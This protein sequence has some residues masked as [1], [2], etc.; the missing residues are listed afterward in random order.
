MSF[1]DIRYD[2]IRLL[3]N[4]SKIKGEKKAGFLINNLSKSIKKLEENIRVRNTISVFD[5]I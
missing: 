1:F 5:N 4:I 2:L 3:G